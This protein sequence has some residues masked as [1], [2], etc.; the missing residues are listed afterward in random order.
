MSFQLKSGRSWSETC[1]RVHGATEAFP[2]DRLRDLVSG[3]GERCSLLP[4]R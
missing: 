3:D 4:G 2:S 1:G